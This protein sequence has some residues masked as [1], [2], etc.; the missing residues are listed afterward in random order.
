M[1][2]Y[3]ELTATDCLHLG[4]ISLEQIQF[5]AAYDWFKQVYILAPNDSEIAQDQTMNSVMETYRE[6]SRGSEIIQLNFKRELTAIF[7]HYLLSILRR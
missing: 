2:D 1:F 7:M 6:V 3:T 4:K 5:N